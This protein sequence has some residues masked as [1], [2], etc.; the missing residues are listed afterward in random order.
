MTINAASY[1]YVMFIIVAMGRD[2]KKVEKMFDMRNPP[3]NV[4]NKIEIT[5]VDSS[6][7]FANTNFSGGSSSVRIPYL[8]GA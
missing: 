2:R 6:Q 4:P 5:V 8:A 3:S 1:V 7:P